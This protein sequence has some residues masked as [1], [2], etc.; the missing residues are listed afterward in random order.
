MLLRRLI[1]VS[2]NE[3]QVP[4]GSVVLTARPVRVIWC[5]TLSDRL[6]GNCLVRPVYRFAQTDCTRW[7]MERFISWNEQCSRHIDWACHW[8]LQERL[9]ITYLSVEHIPTLEHWLPSEFMLHVTSLLALPAYSMRSRVY[10]TVRCPSV[11]LSYT[12]AAAACGGFA[13]VSQV[14]R[15]YRSIAARLAPQHHDV[16]R[17]SKCV[18]SARR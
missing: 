9:R 11:C 1:P 16:Q 6:T 8:M 10:E 2:C 12:P 7:Y 14:G 5:H 15:R 17:S 13:A 4:R 18:F 3:S